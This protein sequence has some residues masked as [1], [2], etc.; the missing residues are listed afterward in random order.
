MSMMVNPF[1]GWRWD[2][3]K[4]NLSE[5]PWTRIQRTD[6]RKTFLFHLE[7]SIHTLIHA[8][9]FNLTLNFSPHLTNS[10]FASLNVLA[11]S[12]SLSLSFFSAN[13]KSCLRLSAALL[14][15][16]LPSAQT[17]SILCPFNLSNPI[18]S[19][20]IRLDPIQSN[21]VQSSIPKLHSKIGH[22][23]D[24]NSRQCVSSFRFP[25]V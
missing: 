3:W 15:P 10:L 21:P 5:S 22:P 2:D 18:S 16:L 13:C 9:F 4:T 8:R 23:F 14:H 6:W 1:E 25:W 11:R 7:R 19:D 20:P 12:L 24:L 17:F